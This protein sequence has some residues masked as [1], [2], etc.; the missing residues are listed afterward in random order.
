MSSPYLPDNTDPCFIALIEIYKAAD[1]EF[2]H[3]K[4]ISLAQWGLESGWGLSDLAMECNNFAGM[5]WRPSMAPYGTPRAYT[6]WQGKEDPYVNF[7]N[8]EAFI[9]GFWARFDLVSAYDGWRKHVDTPDRWIEFI[10][11][12]WVGMSKTH[13]MKYVNNIKRIYRTRTKFIIP[14]RNKDNE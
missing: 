9:A 2:P 13:N 11:P 1:I 3:L 12:K 5:K 7:R 14:Y 6:D 4:G 8:K 10:G